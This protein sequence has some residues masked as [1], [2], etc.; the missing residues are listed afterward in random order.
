MNKKGMSF[1]DV[2]AWIV[3]ALILLWL[4]LKVIGVI[5]TPDL[6]EYAPYFGI[7]YLDGWAMSSLFRTVEDVKM[8]KRNL[9]FLNKKINELVKDIE[10]IKISHRKNNLFFLLERLS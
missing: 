9:S 7:V 2:L 4:I 8:I 6:I 5:S 10:I 3:L 1:W